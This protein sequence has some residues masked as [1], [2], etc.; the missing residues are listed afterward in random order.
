MHLNKSRIRHAARATGVHFGI[1]LIVA[2][3]IGFLV[4][5]IWYPYPFS[6]MAA[7]RELFILVMLVD[8][9]C[10]P[11]LTLILYS[12]VKPRR[13]LITDLSLVAI[14]QLAALAYGMWT[15]WLV[16]PLYLVYEFDRFKVITISDLDSQSLSRLPAQLKPHIFEGPLIV[17]LREPTA[18][19]REKVLFE[20]VDGGK[21]YGE[22][23]EFYEK[24]NGEEAYKKAHTLTKFRGKYPDMS[25]LLDA[26]TR[27]FGAD[28]TQFRYLP[29]IA[30]KDWIVIL[31]PRG[32]LIAYLP[33][34]GF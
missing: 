33:G 18:Q 25:A 11:L 22:R 1:S 3:L 8:L 5:V 7:G 21:D 32:E 16:K 24:Y 14:L 30:R 15:V 2:L 9:V 13:E 27:K 19:E 4:L 10:G 6:E 12:P 31:N 28:S 20:S 34:D 26:T 29:I 17:G 23:P